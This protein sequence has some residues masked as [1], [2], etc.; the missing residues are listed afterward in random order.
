MQTTSST[1]A[2]VVATTNATG[3]PMMLDTRSAPEI[4]HTALV[5]QRATITRSAA[6]AVSGSARLVTDVIVAQRRVD[7]IRRELDRSARDA[8][9]R[10]PMSTH[11][12]RIRRGIVDDVQRGCG[13]T[14]AE[15]EGLDQP[16]HARAASPAAA[17]RACAIRVTRAVRV[18]DASR[19]NNT[20][21]RAT[22]TMTP[23]ATP[24][25]PAPL[26]AFKEPCGDSA[27]RTATVVSDHDGGRVRRADRCHTGEQALRL[28]A[29]PIVRT[30]P[31]KFLPAR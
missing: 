7:L 3:T 28:M 11:C 16:R 18:R 20:E 17:V 27:S 31:R 14:A 5:H 25:A 15:R 4:V 23:S 9:G 8:H 29:G 26:G 10:R 13:E 22:T 30:P 21:K 24:T 2:S 1:I 6:A 19:A 12:E